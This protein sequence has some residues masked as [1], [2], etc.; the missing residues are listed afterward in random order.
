MCS[1]CYSRCQHTGWD[2]IVAEFDEIVFESYPVEQP[3]LPEYEVEDEEPPEQTI[4]PTEPEYGEGDYDYYPGPGDLPPV[5]E[6]EVEYE[7]EADKPSADYYPPEEEQELEEPEEEAPA[8]DEEPDF[9]DLGDMPADLAAALLAYAEGAQ[10]AIANRSPIAPAAMPGD[11]G[12]IQFTN[13]SPGN[14][15]IDLNY[16]PVINWVNRPGEAMTPFCA[17]FGPDPR[18]GVPYVA[19]A[20]SNTQIL[21]LLVAYEQGLTS[22]RLGVQVA[23]WGITEGWQS[24]ANWD[25][26]AAARTAGQSAD[27]TGWRLLRFT[28][29][30]GS[31]PLFAVV[32]PDDD[33]PYDP[34]DPYDP[35]DDDE[36]EFE[37]RWSIESY[38]ET[39]F[40]REASIEITDARGQLMIRK[41]NQNHDP[42][43]GA[44]FDIRITFSDGT[45]QQ[46]NGW[47]AYNGGRLLTWNHPVGNRDAATV[48]VTEVRA[49]Q[50]Y[51]IDVNNTRTVT[52]SPSYT[53]WEHVT[54][55]EETVTTYTY[56]WE[57]I[58]IKND[59]E[60]TVDRIEYS[61]GQNVSRSAW[62]RNTTTDSVVGD[63]HQSVT[64][65]NVRERG[66]LIVYKRC[67]VTG[68]LLSGAEFLVEGIDLGNAGSFS[69][70]GVT[71]PG[72][73]VVFNGLF[74]GTYRV[75]EQRSPFTHNTDAPP[76]T[77]TIQSNELVRVTFDNTRRQGLSILKVD[78]YGN[79][80]QGAVF[81]VRRGSGQVLGSFISDQNGL[82]IIPSHYLTTGYYV[83]EE[84]QAPDFFIID[85]DNNPQTIWIDNSAQNPTYSLVFRNF[86]QPSIEITK[87]CASD[88][89]LKLAGAV[90][91]ITNSQTGQYW[92]ITSDTNGRAYLP[93]LEIGTTYI[94]EE[95]VSPAN[96]VRSLYRQEIVLRENRTHTITLP[97]YREPSLTIIKRCAHTNERLPSATFRVSWQGGA[98]FR[99]VTT[100]PNGEVLLEGLE[101]GWHSIV[102]RTPP[103][104]FL[105]NDETVNIQLAPGEHRVV[106][107]FNERIPNLT[108][109]KICSVT[110]NPLE[111]AR[112]RVERIIDTGI[113]LVGIFTSNE[114][115]LIVLEDVGV[116][117]FRISEESPP[118]GF[119]IDREV[120]EVTILAGQSYEL[121][122]TNTPLAPIFI[123]KTDE[124]GTPLA[125]AEFRVS[126][127]NG[128]LVGY[129][130]SSYTGYAIIPNVQPGWHLV[131]EVRSPEGHIL[132]NVP[133]MV[134]VFAGRPATVSFINYSMPIL[135][136]LKTCSE[137]SR[138]LPGAVFTITEAD[139]RHVGEFT[140]DYAGL[141]TLTLM[142]NVFIIS[143]LRSPDGFILDGTP[144]TVVLE[145]GGGVTQVEHRNTPIPGLLLTKRCR[146]THRVIADTAFNIT[147]V[148]GH[149]R[150]DLGTFVTGEN[151]TIFIPELSEGYL[152]ITE[153]RPS[154]GFFKDP[155]PILFFVEAG[156]LNLIEVFNEP[157][158]NLRLRKICVVS[159]EPLADAIFRLFDYQQREIGTFTTSSTGE[160]FLTGK[161]GGTYFL[162]EISSPPGYLRDST[163]RRI[164]LVGAH[165]TNIEWPNTPLGS[166]RILKVCATTREPLYNVEFELLDYAGTSL[167]RFTTNREGIILLSR[168]LA[169]GTYR[170]RETR[171]SPGFYRDERTHTVVI[172]NEGQTTEIIVENQ[173]LGSLRIVKVCSQ[174]GDRLRGATFLLHDAGNNIIGEHTT[175][176]R[177]E[178][179]LQYT[180]RN[181][182]IRIREIRASAGYVLCDEVREVQTRI[183]ETVEIVIENEP[184]RGRIRVEKRAADANSITGHR[185]GAAIEGVVFGVVNEDL[186]VVYTMTTDSRGVATTGYLPLGRYAIRETRAA[187]FWLLYNGVFY[188][189]IRNH[190]DIVQFEVLNHPVEIDVTVE[191]RGNA[192]ALAGD[193]IRYDFANIANNSNVPLEGFFWRDQ[194]P[195]ELRLER[196]V[197]GTWSERGQFRVVYRTNQNSQYRVWRDNLSTTSSHE[198]NASELRLAEGEFI[199][200]FRLEFGTVAPGFRQV[201][202]PHIYTRVLED[203]PHE[204]RIVNRTDVGGRVNGEY[205]YSTDS[206]VTVVFRAPRGPLP[207]T[208]V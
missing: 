96:F 157:Y 124:R 108:I 63:L 99:D 3:P 39:R 144:R 204:H 87:V 35:P 13:Q 113:E 42:L 8:E 16:W 71:G 69:Q 85:H 172:G 207:Q 140:T 111:H 22:D 142:P 37:V 55:W 112:F 33:D 109:R 1:H 12:T 166:L 46:I 178:I 5:D 170:L 59:E 121:I 103:P 208:G 202:A 62:N 139:G 118:P 156:R 20:H 10:R 175:N 188:A 97:N 44:L 29:P 80:L 198:L 168:N 180:F 81:E 38:T 116:G 43:D 186:E 79:P 148:R 32:P 150:R 152:L 155:E 164:E 131:E 94:V 48:T 70:T 100:G 65:V 102:E 203:L 14:L 78:N 190:G 84:I 122:V 57:V 205:V 132:S 128:N 200:S 197:T 161:P 177:G 89:T 107:F 24:W 141:I 83:V 149:Y 6:D 74:P 45:H 67:A 2:Y 159:R 47:E 127:M 193:I 77:V 104:S 129:A 106:E 110:A 119:A 153:T 76:Q 41:Q 120:H 9:G 146:I 147:E 72:G 206:W 163:V 56:W 196:L 171:E 60:N 136:I 182:T 49:P 11:I 95:K 151:G 34:Y 40:V 195:S 26:A 86:R 123:R 92:D 52:V 15:P 130:T 82:I 18:E 199:T 54:Y 165:T 23:I 58:L 105:L 88:P 30:A 169:P 21:R 162:Q 173:R 194:L 191:K 90:F 66:Q 75:T 192:E 114:Y 91:R 51:T 31:Q 176:E 101:V 160:I 133:V 17:R 158:S 73:Y 167:G 187:E 25:R 134:E 181:E 4:P 201:E 27:I 117:R 28:G 7:P 145:P 137:T 50:H 184:M 185:A 143:E 138:P 19:A 179:F 126:T 174:S 68:Q 189:D 135:Q 64:F 154:P 53:L 36:K 61:S 125:G 115:G 98:S 183:G 93:G